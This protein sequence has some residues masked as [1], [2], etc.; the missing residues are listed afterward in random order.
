MKPIIG[1]LM[2][3]PGPLPSP[4]DD[5]TCAIAPGPLELSAEAPRS[6]PADFNNERRFRLENGWAAET[7]IAVLLARRRSQEQ[8]MRQGRIRM[9]AATWAAAI[10]PVCHNQFNDHRCAAAI[11][12]RNGVE[13]RTHCCAHR[14]GSARRLPRHRHRQPAAPLLRS[15][16]R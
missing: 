12:L 15:R 6:T 16:R 5:E 11:H 8:S 3:W 4:A 9:A 10:S 14:A 13:R 7:Y 2:S 1:W